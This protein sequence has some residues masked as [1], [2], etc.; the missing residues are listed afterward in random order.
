[1]NHYIQLNLPNDLGN[2]WV[3]EVPLGITAT[4]K[5]GTF[6]I[7][8]YDITPDSNRVAIKK[9]LKPGRWTTSFIDRF[10]PNKDE[11]TIEGVF[12]IRKR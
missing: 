12:R 1:M 4:V 6:S 2:I 10:Q 9:K 8:D 7:G 11:Y 3:I 5:N